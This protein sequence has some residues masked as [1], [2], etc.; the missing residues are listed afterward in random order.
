MNGFNAL[1]GQYYHDHQIFINKL[2]KSITSDEVKEYFS[3]FG[4]VL[5]VVTT[6]PE[7]NPDPN[8]QHCYIKLD[9]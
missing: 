6:V 1:I 7:S 3:K 8:V 9:S 2:H 4:K 5:D